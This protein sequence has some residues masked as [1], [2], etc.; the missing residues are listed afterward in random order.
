MKYQIKDQEGKISIPPRQSE[1]GTKFPTDEYFGCIYGRIGLGAPTF[2]ESFHL[3]TWI[4]PN[5]KVNKI[6][7]MLEKA[8]CKPS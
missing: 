4:I 7:K 1:S 8:G 2:D 5:K 3:E 6:T